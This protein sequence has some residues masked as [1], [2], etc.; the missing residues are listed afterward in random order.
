MTVSL[1]AF[2][3]RVQAEELN[4]FGIAVQQHGEIVATHR[5]APDEPHVLHSL[6]KSY[7]VMGVGMLVDEG[8][9]SIHDKVIDFFPDK[10]P[11]VV[12]ERLAAMEVYH[13]LTMTCGHKEPFMMGT[14]RP[15]IPG[16]DW[17]RFFLAND[18]EVMP[19]TRFLYE[20]GCT[21][22]LSAIIT[23]ITGQTALDF[24]MPRLFEPMGITERPYWV[25]CP[26]GITEG[27]AGL[28][29]RTEQILPFGEM[30]LHEGVY[31]GQRLV[32]AEWIKAATTRQVDSSLD[33]GRD[34]YNGYGY[35]FWI[36]H[37]GT[38]RGSG[39]DGQFLIV[40]AEQDAVIT[41]NSQEPRQQ[42]ILD[43]IWDLV[44][45]QL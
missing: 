31:N 17:V 20:S 11:E 7:L 18:P 5:F 33:R 19:G 12:S 4:V 37:N 24:L 9:L 41:V 22:M 16:G 30:I 13:L 42:A 1:Q 36:S 10:L 21:Y 34:W 44:A 29:L 14:A 6:S 15:H 35:Q 38:P 39:A 43:C 27:C 8:K 23:K 3:D 45:P 32:S 2:I 26:M 25:H 40:M 28:Y